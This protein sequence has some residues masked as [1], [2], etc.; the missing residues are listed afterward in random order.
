[1]LQELKSW[2]VRVLIW[3]QAYTKTDMVYFASGGFWL[4]LGQVVSSFSAF[5]LAIAFANFTSPETYGTYKYILS[6]AG[7]FSIF[8][9]PG[10][11]T[12]LARAVANGHASSIH[13][14][15]RSR[16]F[17]ACIGCA[18]A[19]AGS[20]YYFFNE[21][22]QL[23]LA[24][25]MIAVTLPFFDTFTTYLFYFVGK[26]RFDLRTTYNAVTQMVSTL[27]L[28]ATIACTDNLL[29]ILAAYFI[30]LIFMRAAIYLRIARNMPRTETAHEDAH[31]I[32]YGKHL[33]VMQIL[34][35]IGAEM[36]KIL[37]WKFLGPSQVAIYTLALAIPEQLKGPLKGV[38]ELAFPKFAAQTPE[39]IRANMPALWRKLALYAFVLLGISIAYILTVP[40]IFQIF[41]PQYMASV[42]YS[43]L[44]ALSIV[45]YTASIPIALLAAQKKT[46]IQYIASIVQ[47]I[48]AIGLLAALIPLY[49]IWGAIIALVISRFFTAA[50][51][52]ITLFR[53]R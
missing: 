1:M 4:F 23:S 39:D 11:N 22:S 19:L 30:P 25:F 20:A 8:S 45:G 47:P 6:L 2:F 10:M 32:R 34:G 5:I 53:L 48:V 50:I 46:L 13:A 3:S 12:A 38:G 43:Q 9:L 27:A 29:L 28:L 49:G 51:Y 40:Y 16:I 41:F 14:V 37:I 17:H 24:L 44:F 15:T 36:D 31:V 35:M 21:N 33:T 18:F 52:L 26:K 7:L 42:P